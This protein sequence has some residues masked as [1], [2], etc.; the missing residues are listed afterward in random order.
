MEASDRHPPGSHRKFL[1]I[2]IK[3]IKNFIN[4]VY[5]TDFFCKN[6][7]NHCYILRVASSF[8]LFNF[9]WIRRWAHLNEFNTVCIILMRDELPAHW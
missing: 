2:N 9:L 6:E 8:L 5:I 1:G 3:L 4:E 7:T